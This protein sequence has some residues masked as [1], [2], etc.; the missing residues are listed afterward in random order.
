MLGR[1]LVVPLAVVG[2][3]AVGGVA[4]AVMGVPGLSG[5]STPGATADPDDCPELAEPR[6]P[7]ASWGR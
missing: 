6:L 2:S 3:V 4:G 5:A 1:R 7:P